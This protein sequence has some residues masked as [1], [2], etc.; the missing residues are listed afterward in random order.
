MT[1]IERIGIIGTAQSWRQTPWTDPGLSLWSLNDAYRMQGFV[2]ADAWFDLHPLSHFFTP[3][4]EQPIFAHQVPA[5]AYCRPV[6]H[7]A[8]L[9]RQASTIPVWL[10]PDWQTQ[11]PADAA[12]IPAWEALK[13]MPNAHAFPKAEIEA[14]C[15]RYFTSSPAW[16]IAHAL[17]QGCKELHIYG[18]HLATEF[19][20]VHQRPNFE[21]LC[22]RLLGAGAVKMTLSGGLR[23]YES[24]SG[25]LVLPESSPVL[26]E[27]FQY[28]FEQR[29][30]AGQE[31]LKWDVHR[32][33]VKRERAIQQLRQAGWWQRTAAI[34]D[35]LTRADAYLQD[36]QEGLQRQKVA[37]GWK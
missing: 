18:I 23:R 31:I 29:P 33:S 1:P 12:Q 16:M 14:W 6:D 2:R 5:G 24:Q 9:S 13:A 11:T 15:G 3:P 8:W 4:K 17:M 10:H 28:A 7:I 25:I 34:R 21:F 27:R 22:G 20:Y 30:D 36:A 35:D 26:Q 19:E 32:F 37:Q